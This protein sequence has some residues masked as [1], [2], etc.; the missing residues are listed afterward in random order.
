MFSLESDNQGILIPSMTKTQRDAI[1]NPNEGLL[2][3]QN[4]SPSEFYYYDG[5]DWVKVA[6][7]NVSVSSSEIADNDGGENNLADGGHSTISVAS[8][9]LSY[10]IQF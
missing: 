2:I 6:D 5:S 7:G 1:I 10:Q 8:L 4:T 3:Y 9:D